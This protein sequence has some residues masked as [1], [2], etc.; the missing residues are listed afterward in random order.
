MEQFSR[1]GVKSNDGSSAGDLMKRFAIRLLLPCLI[2]FCFVLPSGA[3]RQDTASQQTH[4][5]QK[6]ARK[7]QKAMQKNAKHQQKAMRKSDKAQKKALKRAHE[8]GSW[9]STAGQH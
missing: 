9:V 5:Y 1:L 6:A 7:A 8:Q 2:S 3:S 4:A